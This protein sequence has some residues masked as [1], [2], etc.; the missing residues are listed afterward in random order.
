M[1]LFGRK[2][3]SSKLVRMG[4][5]GPGTLVRIGNKGASL[6]KRYAGPIQ[7]V[8]KTA[9]KVGEAIQTGK[10]IKERGMS[11]LRGD[12]SQ[13]REILRDGQ[14]LVHQSREIASEAKDTIQR[15]RRK[16]VNEQGMKFV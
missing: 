11:L 6:I 14:R 2:F 3:A 8:V 15:V 7:Q 10:Q 5:K 9:Q 16:P 12:I 1:G 13:A 4:I